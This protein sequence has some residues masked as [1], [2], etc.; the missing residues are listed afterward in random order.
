M[1]AEEFI[2]YENGIFR[3][4]KECQTADKEWEHYNNTKTKGNI[5]CPLCRTPP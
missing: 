5:M 3:Y 4:H 2:N 1:N